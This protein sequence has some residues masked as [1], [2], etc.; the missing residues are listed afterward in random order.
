MTGRKGRVV[1]NVDG[2]YSYEPRSK[3]DVSLEM[4]N[5]AEKKRFMNGEKVIN[6]L[7]LFMKA[8]FVEWYYSK[9]IRIYRA[10]S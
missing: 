7:L 5:L 9:D 3:D 8:V 10:N 6:L 1:A 4:L 2:S